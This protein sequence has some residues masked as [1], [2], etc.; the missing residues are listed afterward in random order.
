MLDRYKI[1]LAL[2]EKLEEHDILYHQKNRPIISDA[3]YDKLKTNYLKRL[4]SYPEIE[5]S[6][7]APPSNKFQKIEHTQPMLSLKNAF[8]KKDV[9][10][11]IDRTHNFLHTQ[12]KLEIVCEPKIDGI[13]FAAHYKT[14]KL[15]W[16]STRGDG[17]FGEDITANIKTIKG[18][19]LEL[20][21]APETFEIRGEVFIEH[22]DFRLMNGFS[23]PRNAAGGSLRH[24]DHNI[25]AKRPLKYFA[26][27]AFGLEDCETH[28]EV[29]KR[30]HELSFSINEYLLITDNIEKIITFYEEI[31]SMRSDI[32]YDIDGVVY[33]INNLYLQQ[34]L[35]STNHSP[36]WAIAH[37]FPAKQA[38]ARL[39]KITI[40]VGRTGAITPI[41]E[42][43]PI[44]IGGVIVKRASLHNADEIKRKDIRE[45]DIV[46][47][48]R[49]GDVI[50]QIIKV[51]KNFRSTSS[52]KF[53]FPNFCPACNSKLEKE[54]VITRCSAKLTCTAQTIEKIKHMCSSLKIHGLKEKQIKLLLQE[55]IIENTLDV[56]RIP[57]KIKQLELIPGWGQK[58]ATKLATNIKN[59]KNVTLDKFILSLG[60]RFVGERNALI[61]AREFPSY[62]E[63]Y[64][65]MLNATKRQSVYDE[66]KNIDG[67]GEKIA[68]SIKSFFSNVDNLS[69]LNKLH[70]QINVKNF[71]RKE[72]LPLQGKNIVFT[73]TITN[74]T[75]AEAK[76]KAQSMGANVMNALSNNVDILIVGTK[77]G[78]KIAK[79]KK[80]NIKIINEDDWLNI[81]KKS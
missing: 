73:G 9:E 2:K 62:E 26:Y 24:L 40:Q 80:L 18:L 1:L 31:Y 71:Q 34:R 57:E 27:T 38:K 19:P 15:K 67:I 23:N 60:I 3:E 25:T 14:G 33:K 16:A 12:E 78:S 65:N 75:R 74:I 8:K 42:L 54:G 37:K 58:S 10:D 49:A 17:K 56:F 36:R 29:L 11:F 50:P 7:G 21:N 66:I 45:N 28:S 39:K 30:L 5:L 35:G 63:W 41:A 64:D 46:I 79:A 77:S 47:I 70:Q 76:S 61:L 69:D 81:I 59:T 4:K 32:P 51:D 52:A 55:K 6:V 53:V 72:N 20:E 68:C 22:N 48:K 43:E 44:N 13:S